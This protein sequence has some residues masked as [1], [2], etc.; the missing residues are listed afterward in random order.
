MFKSILIAALAGCLLSATAAHAATPDHYGPFSDSYSFIGPRCDGF[1]IRIEG[2]ETRSATVFYD[3]Q[4]QPDRIIEQVA[5]P[6]DVLTNTVSGG[7]I[8]LRAEFTHHYERNPG[9]ETFRVAI[10]GHRYFVTRAGEG[11]VLRDVGRIVYAT[12]TQ[13]EVLFAAG[14]HELAYDADIDPVL[15]RALA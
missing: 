7:S 3:D 6:H 13:E 8:V 12:G 10:T 5:T 14:E 1:D 15:C 9:T 2:T 11:V 4:G